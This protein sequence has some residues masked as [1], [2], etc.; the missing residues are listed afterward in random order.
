MDLQVNSMDL[1]VNSM[2]LP[3]NSMDLPVNSMALQVNSMALQVNSMDQPVNSMDQPIN[4]MDQPDNS[5]DLPVRPISPPI[6]PIAARASLSEPRSA[7][8]R[9]RDHE[10]VLA[11]LGSAQRV[12]YLQD[13]PIRRARVGHHDRL[14][15]GRSPAGALPLPQALDG[16]GEGDQEEVVLA[17]SLGRERG[18][19]LGHLLARGEDHDGRRIVAQGDAGAAHQ[20]D[21]RL[22]R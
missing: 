18:A 20:D 5:M 13:Q 11:H 17:P 7:R 10:V 9:P 22:G 4:S 19:V 21:Q 15:G 3:D 8:L 12:E 2:D 16:V 6:E 14:P 1:Q